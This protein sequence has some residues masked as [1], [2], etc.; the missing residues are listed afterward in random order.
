MIPTKLGNT[1]ESVSSS[2]RWYFVGR[3][4]RGWQRMRWLDGITDLMDMSLSQLRELVMDGVLWF[5]GLQRV[6]HSWATELNCGRHN[7][8]PSWRVQFTAWTVEILVAAYLVKD[9]LT[10]AQKFLFFAHVHVPLTCVRQE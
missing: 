7:T 3:R 9:T 8:Y 4:R 1:A 10:N 5:V 6:R 2:F